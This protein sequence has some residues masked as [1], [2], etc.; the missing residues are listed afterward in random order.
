[1]DTLHDF[2][3]SDTPEMRDLLTM[4]QRRMLKEAA[5]AA[6]TQP[7]FERELRDL[8]RALERR[9]HVADFQRLDVDVHGIMVDGVRY[10]RRGEKTVGH[11]MTLAGKIEVPRTTYRERGGHGGETVTPLE[12]RL[13]LVDGHWTLAA[14][15]AASAFMAAV[16]SKEA[17]DL[18][19]AA[20]TM[21]PSSSHLDRLPKLVSAAWEADRERFEAAVRDAERLDLPDPEDVAHIAFS[22]DGIMVPMKDAPRTPG[23]GKRDQG[24]KGHKEVGC[25]TVSLYDSKGE[26]LHTVRFARMPEPH[27]STLHEQ[28][29]AELQAMHARYPAATIQAVADAAQDNWR[30]VEELAAALGCEVEQTVDYFHAAEHL[31][32]GLRA[33]GASNEEIVTW[34]LTLRDAANGT[35]Q[36]I[37]EL[38]ARTRKWGR[39]V[40]DEALFFVGQADRMRYSSVAAAHHPI[41]SGVQEAACKTLVADRMKR[42]GMSWREPGGQAILTLRGLSQSGRLGH[43]WQALRPALTRRFDIDPNLRRQP[44]TRAAA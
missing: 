15:E 4:I 38:Y 20:G 18:L 26:R 17:A 44:P 31:A 16:P 12:L 28:L 27:K 7:E 21:N 9:I 3:L 39:A 23:A 36:V 42:S 1:M 29:L 34:K 35:E 24:P 13:G 14:A 6:S 37:D 32:D 8:M 5:E 30:I 43:A 2:N 11:Y 22:L 19:V 40:E 10:R 25:A 33:G 41:G